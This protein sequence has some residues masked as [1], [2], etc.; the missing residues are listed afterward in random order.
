MGFLG[1][2]SPFE[3]IGTII[4][5]IGIYAFSIN[6]KLQQ[7]DVRAKEEARNFRDLF[8]ERY[9]LLTDLVAVIRENDIK[10]KEAIA[11]VVNARAVAS[12]AKEYLEKVDSDSKF[13]LA[14]VKLF[15]TLE[16]YPKIEEDEWY[17][18]IKKKY[19]QLNISMDELGKK[20][21]VTAKSFNDMVTK[22]PS[23][24]ISDFRKYKPLPLFLTIEEAKKSI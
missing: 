17:I 18:D 15:K 24:I 5:F 7:V 9:F 13:T 21:N 3:L 20:Y 11:E 14:L 22:Q 1:G 16:K 6:Y 12:K 8:S 19:E 2:I 10:E 23:K 4:L